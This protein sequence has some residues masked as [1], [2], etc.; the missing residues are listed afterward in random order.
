METVRVLPPPEE[1]V[2]TVDEK[3]R[4]DIGRAKKQ[5]F[6]SVSQFREVE[7]ALPV[8]P[9]SDSRLLSRHRTSRLSV[10]PSWLSEKLPSSRKSCTRTRSSNWRCSWRTLNCTRGMDVT[11]QAHPRLVDWP[12]MSPPA[13]LR[14]GCCYE[15]AMTRKF[16]HGR[17]ET[18]RPCTV[19]AVKWCT[20]MTDPS[21]EVC[22]PKL[23]RCRGWRGGPGLTRA[24][25][26]FRTMQRGKQCSWPL[27]NTTSWWP[28]PRKD[29]VSHALYFFCLSL[30]GRTNIS[31]YVVALAGAGFDRHLLGLYLIAKEEGRPVPELFLDPLYAK[32]YC[33]ESAARVLS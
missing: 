24:D 23:R 2:F 21:C 18:M 3:L 19:E 31:C 9:W 33:V 25:F 28:R 6:E 29:E 17:T 20:A 26:C 7:L 32:R 10:T 1:L 14:P 27:R 13:P 22:F 8:W 5:Y 4:G 30:M 15:T 12:G 11:Q 16:Y